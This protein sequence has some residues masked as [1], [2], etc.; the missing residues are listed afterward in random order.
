M[1]LGVDE[2][3]D[4]DALKKEFENRFPGMTLNL[5]TELS[6]Y[7]SVR[8]DEQLAA[9]HVYVDSIA[10]QTV[11]DFPRLDAEGALLHYAPVGFDQLYPPAATSRPPRGTRAFSTCPAP[12]SPT[13]ASGCRTAPGWSACGLGLRISWELRRGSAR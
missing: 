6:E 7:H 9:G 10:F 8:F 11:H 3:T 12:T 1:W 5:T 13:S 2:R 4:A